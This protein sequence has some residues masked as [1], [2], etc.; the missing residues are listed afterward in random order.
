MKHLIF[1]SLIFIPAYGMAQ[2]PEADNKRI[3]D[4]NKRAFSVNTTIEYK[5]AYNAQPANNKP[6]SSTYSNKGN[7]NAQSVANV[8]SALGKLGATIDRNRAEKANEIKRGL[9]FDD[10]KSA[11]KFGDWLWLETK[12][13]DDN[14]YRYFKKSE[15]NIEH[16][17][18][19]YTWTIL[20]LDNIGRN[21]Y[22]YEVEFNVDKVNFDK[23][24]IGILLEID[25]IKNAKTND[26][27]MFI[28]DPENKMYWIG[29]FS[30]TDNNKWTTYNENPIADKGNWSSFDG[31]NTF[32]DKGSSVNTLRIKK[33]QNDIMFFVN[34]KNLLHFYI[35]DK[36]YFYNLVG[37]GIC[38]AN[39]LRAKVSKIQFQA[40]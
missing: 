21:S 37:V 3:M 7:T 12:K 24:Y 25:A 2:T 17:S 36:P 34:G 16:Y 6:T 31:I 4:G 38:E 22:I 9:L 32:D 8:G 15:L 20:P 13:D 39:K 18:N 11:R 28:I 40:N 10:W 23:G 30:K 27:L 19:D 35:T 33:F 29:N 14:V 26:K 1:A 5:M